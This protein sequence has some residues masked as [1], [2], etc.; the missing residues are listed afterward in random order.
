MK[1]VASVIKIKS[2]DQIRKWIKTLPIKVD[3]IS[4]VE[5][6][7]NSD[8]FNHIVWLAGQGFRFYK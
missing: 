2:H 7:E 1:K 4:L 3:E 8:H 6:L 5:I